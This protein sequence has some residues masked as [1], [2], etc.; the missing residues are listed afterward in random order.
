MLQRRNNDNDQSRQQDG[1]TLIELM[2]V[3]AIVAI[4]T[5]IALPSYQQQVRQ[6]RRSD[7][8]VLLSTLANRQQQQW[9]RT[10]A[11]SDDISVLGG[12]ESVQGFYELT[13]VLSGD[14]SVSLPVGSGSVALMCTTVPC[15]IAAAVPQGAQLADTDCAVFTVD[16]LGRKRS[17]DHNGQQN[18]P[19]HEDPCW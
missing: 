16:H 3:L 7:A 12:E 19:G 15:F 10:A 2:M 18:S 6:S 8:H 17:Y 1:F 5:A 4:L 11:Y 13:V 14:D 9:A